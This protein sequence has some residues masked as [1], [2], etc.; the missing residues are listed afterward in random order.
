MLKILICC[1]GGFSSSYVTER[2]K[3]EVVEKKLQDEVYIEF[4]PFS[5]VKE[6][7]KDFDIVMCCPHLKIYVDRLLNE[8]TMSIPIYLLPPKMYGFMQLEEIMLDAK[9]VIAIYQE[10]K[11][12]PVHFPGEEKLLRIQRG[13]AYR[14]INKS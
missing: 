4:Y 11:M 5:L 1:G 2:M 13:V 10:T 8:T 3:K 9:D 14:N 7:E 12:N 6:K